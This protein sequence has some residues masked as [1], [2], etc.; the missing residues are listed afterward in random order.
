MLSEALLAAGQKVGEPL[1]QLPLDPRYDQQL[2]S[3]VADLKNVGGRSASAVTAARFLAHFIGD[4]PW[5]HLDIAG[6]ETYS[7]GLEQTPRSYLT[8][9]GT[10]ITTR[11]LVE[12]VRNWEQAD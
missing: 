5:A 9:G 3:Q 8:K 1:W 12:L 6:S 11:T 2:K 4:W 7:N 10:G